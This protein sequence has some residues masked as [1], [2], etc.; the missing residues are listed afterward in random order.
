MKG[1][2]PRLLMAAGLSASLI[3]ISGR[4]GAYQEKP[5]TNGGSLHG[6]VTFS[7][8][9]PRPQV[10]RVRDFPNFDYCRKKADALGNREV[11][12]VRVGENGAL[13]D[14]IVVIEDVDGGKPFH[15]EGARVN[16]EDCDFV[17]QGGPSPLLGVLVDDSELQILN[18]DADPT[19]PETI[20]GVMHNPQGLEI[21]GDKKKLLFKLVISLKG[22]TSKR[23]VHFKNKGDYLL[24]MCDV[25]TYMQSYFL[26]VNNPY[27]AVVDGNGNYSIDKIPPGN[28]TVTAWNPSLGKIQKEITIRPN[29]TAE[30]EFQF[31]N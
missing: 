22:Q 30:L 3:F 1:P 6:K 14:A 4:A 13:R 31:E 9:V 16:S 23:K 19:H 24:V 18:L 7:G 27:Y 2:F 25:H 12:P 10:Y 17:V 15:F 20:Q 8:T 28:Y 29:G 11:Q 5:V 21:L 26:Q